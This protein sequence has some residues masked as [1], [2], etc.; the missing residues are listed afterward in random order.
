MCIMREQGSRSLCWACAHCSQHTYLLLRLARISIPA[1][2]TYG[3]QP[4]PCVR[5]QDSRHAAWLV[6]P[7]CTQQTWGA[8]LLRRLGCKHGRPR[9]L[10]FPQC[11][12]AWCRRKV[13]REARLPCR[14][15]W[16]SCLRLQPWWARCALKSTCCRHC[17]RSCQAGWLTCVGYWQAGEADSLAWGAG[18][19]VRL[20]HLRG[21]WQAGEADS[22]AWVLA[23]R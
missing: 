15:Q 20:T 4:C 18:K 1:L 9:T 2:V 11:T 6:T 12:R 7:V 3:H 14:Q 10:P 17:C 5:Q 21:C 19:Q 8:V 16:P 22:L 13:A 23:S